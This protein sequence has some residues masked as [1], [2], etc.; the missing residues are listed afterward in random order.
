M[1]NTLLST[2][3]RTKATVAISIELPEQYRGAAGKDK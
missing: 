2:S 3:H 1:R